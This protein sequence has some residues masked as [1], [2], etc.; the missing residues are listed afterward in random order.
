MG[1]HNTRRIVVMMASLFVYLAALVFSMLAGS[2]VIDVLFLQGI[3][4]VSE[5]YDTDVTPVGWTFSIWGLI[6]SW[7]SCA[8]VYLLAGLCRRILAV[9]AIFS[10]LVA[11]TG[12]LVIFF[13]CHGLKVYGAWL[14]RYHRLDLWLIRVLVQN[15]VALYATWTSSIVFLNL[16]VVL[17]HQVGVSPSDATTLCLALLMIA[18][19][20]W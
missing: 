13:S 10:V 12:Y 1:D 17:V 7:L 4:R 6:Y 5:K 14:Y 11:S 20:A 9:G 19:L 15:G 8:M 2:G 16:A 18:T 3:R